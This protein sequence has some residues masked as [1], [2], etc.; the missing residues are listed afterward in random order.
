MLVNDSLEK[1]IAITALEQVFDPEI[2]L[3]II[4][5]G[6][7]YDI[8][9]DDKSEAVTVIMTLTTSMCPMG[10]S[11]QNN[12][13]STMKLYFSNYTI[14]V[15]LVYDPIWTHDNISEKGKEFLNAY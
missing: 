15:K 1:G 10:Q 12:V 9:F 13:S 2:G 3:N 14:N 4:D 5:L 7:I 11:I 6:L 8:I